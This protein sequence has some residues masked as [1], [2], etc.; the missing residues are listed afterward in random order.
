MT[1]L[2]R[3]RRAPD[4]R[5]L[6]YQAVWG[7][8]DN[9][10]SYAVGDT[11]E[12]ALRLVP[13]Y[14]AHRLIIDQ[15]S[16]TP[17]HAFRRTADG[18]RQ[19]IADPPLIA[20]PSA[21]R[22][23]YAWKAQAVASCLAYGNAYGLVTMQDDGG[24]ATAVEW[25]PPLDVDVDDQNPADPRYSLNGKEIPRSRMLHVPWIVQPGKVKGLSP[26]AAFRVAFDTGASAQVSARDWFANG[27]IPSGHLHNTA[28]TVG[29]T[30]ADEIKS[31]FRAAV[32]GRDV[33]VTGTDWTYTTIG[34]PADE[35]RFIETLRLTAT[36]IASIYGV[37]P[38]KI[39]GEMN[40][41]LT[42]STLEQNTLDFMAFAMR[43]WFTRF[44]EA[45]TSV[46]PQDV[47]VKFNADAMVRTDLLTRMQAHEIAQRSGVAT[48]S[49]T[50]ALEDRPP[51]T[52]AERNEWLNM[53]R[54]ATIPQD[55]RALGS[56]DD[57]DR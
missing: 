10:V 15:F 9:V 11:A 51:L 23:L 4:A 42:Y 46:L 8:G 34:I 38:E 25:L 24:Y 20:Q 44:E 31:R 57:A 56:D 7:R 6:S 35:A 36:Q 43:P 18:G 45:L 52:T 55:L 22:G 26:L 3:S 2:F 27:A 47:Y 14:A 50:R 12:S 41:S 17:L 1:I 28:K 48:N 49:E 19:S 53:W 37:P 54:N 13:L 40:S 16:S 5:S 32:S 30:D 21:A 39:G 29:P 33:L